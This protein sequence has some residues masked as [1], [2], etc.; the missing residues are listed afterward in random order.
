MTQPNAAVHAGQ[1]K[2]QIPMFAKRNLTW[3]GPA[4]LVTRFRA[5]FEKTKKNATRLDPTRLGVKP[6]LARIT[7][8]IKNVTR[9]G[10][11]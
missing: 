5:E 9:P 3:P 7:K 10:P 11:T 1:W 4:F 6:G 2:N 8:K